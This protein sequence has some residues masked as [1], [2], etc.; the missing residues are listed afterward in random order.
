M[1]PNG[2]APFGPRKMPNGRHHGWVSLP[3][4]FNGGVETAADRQHRWRH[5]AECAF[6]YE[7]TDYK[8]NW[9]H[10][11]ETWDSLAGW[12]LPDRGNDFISV[13][14]NLRAA[15]TTDIDLMLYGWAQ[16]DCPNYLLVA[17]TRNPGIFFF[18]DGLHDGAAGDA[19]FLQ[20]LRQGARHRSDS[21]PMVTRQHSA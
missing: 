5:Y 2:S 17:L 16:M 7:G 8:P 19:A 12:P 3:E 1:T 4:S 14:D 6:Y 18:A 13:R 20:A 11:L 9:D 15:L 10:S 21:A